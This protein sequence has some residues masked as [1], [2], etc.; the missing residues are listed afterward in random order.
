MRDP[1]LCTAA[2]CASLRTGLS[3][4]SMLDTVRGRTQQIPHQLSG[5]SGTPNQPS[6][7]PQNELLARLPRSDREHLLRRMERCALDHREVLVEANE[8]IRHVYFPLSGVV[9]LV[10]GTV[11]GATLEVA[12]VGRRAW[13]SCPPCSVARASRSA[14]SSRCRARP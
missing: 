4:L 14:R 1:T 10:I 6:P 12:M 5:M 11:N 13:S 9:S 2:D 3:L 7:A 8:V